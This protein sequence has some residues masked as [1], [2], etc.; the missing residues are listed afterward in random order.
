MKITNDLIQPTVEFGIGGYSANAIE[1]ES[2]NLAFKSSL[3]IKPTEHAGLETI[4]ENG[5]C[6]KQFDLAQ[7]R[8]TTQNFLVV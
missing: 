4:Y 2:R 8:N 6:M 7:I 3:E 1:L 5:I